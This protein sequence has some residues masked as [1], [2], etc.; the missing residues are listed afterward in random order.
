MSCCR[1]SIAQLDL[2][3]VV[4]TAGNKRVQEL[5]RNLNSECERGIAGSSLQMNFENLRVIVNDVFKINFPAASTSASPSMI[6]DRNSTGENQAHD[7]VGYA[8]LARFKA[9]PEYKGDWMQRPVGNNEIG[10]LARFLVILSIAINKRFGLGQPVTREPREQHDGNAVLAYIAW[11]VRIVRAQA[12]RISRKEWRVNLRG[13][14]D[15][16][17]AALLFCVLA[18]YKLVF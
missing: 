1:A 5:M 14:A 15:K 17:I 8:R 13:I 16:K 4:T 9:A 11:V 2:A 10:F 18:F 12:G 3:C 7:S 6:P